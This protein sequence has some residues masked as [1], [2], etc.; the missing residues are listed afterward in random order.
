[1]E[2]VSEAAS[3]HDHR[4][5][6]K[7]HLDGCHFWGSVFVCSCGAKRTAGG[8]RDLADD[9]YSVI[10]MNDD[11]ERCQELLAGTKPKSWDDITV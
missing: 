7:T 6:L 1:V 2:A 5:E 9:P 11:C 4:W 3:E 10:W 8:E